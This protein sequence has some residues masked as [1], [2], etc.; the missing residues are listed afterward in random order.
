MTAIGKEEEEEEVLRRRR[1][2]RMEEILETMESEFDAFEFSK[3]CE[4][5]NS[6][7]GIIMKKKKK[8]KNGAKNDRFGAE[9]GNDDDDDDGRAREGM[10][11]DR[12]FGN[13]SRSNHDDVEDVVVDVVDED[14]DAD[15]DGDDD[16][17][18]L[19]T[20]AMKLFDE[21]ANLEELKV[22]RVRLRKWTKAIERSY[23]QT[24]DYHNITHATDVTQGLG[25]F[26]KH[27]LMEELTSL[28]R[29][30]LI[31]TAVAHDCGHP[32]KSNLFLVKTKSEKAKK[33]NNEAVNENGHVEFSIEV[34]E[35]YHVFEAC[36]KEIKD[37]IYEILKTAILYTDMNKHDKLM[38]DFELALVKEQRNQ[39]Q[40]DNN[41]NNNNNN[42]RL[43]KNWENRKDVHIA[44]G[45]CLHC[46][47]VLN[48]CRPWEV[49]K[50]WADLITEEFCKQ[51]DVEKELGFE[52]L[53]GAHVDRALRTRIT[54]SRQA[55]N[56]GEDTVKPLYG[57]LKFILPDACA[58]LLKHLEA[59]A[60]KHRELIHNDSDNNII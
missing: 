20:M 44:L 32:G 42:S 18:A 52:E 1:R 43:I 47:D 6:E 29:F 19:V 7:G 11:N 36:D 14:V 34:F 24:I 25:F 40:I 9:S 23:D 28:H 38:E 21:Y 16:D 41:N 22:S 8:K 15:D 5:K 54:S 10:G 51:G 12:G 57:L 46:A 27:G 2:R 4:E 49:A 45:Y 60:E 3:L 48:G 50:K 17:G 13:S 26:L 31:I 55:I 59:N 39:Q 33:W 35:K 30:A 37:E 58:T 56:F 53:T